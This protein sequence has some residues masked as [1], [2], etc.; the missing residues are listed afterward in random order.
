MVYDSVV[1]M[2]IITKDCTGLKQRGDWHNLLMKDQ[3][4]V[5]EKISDS[6][7]ITIK[8]ELGKL[9]IVLQNPQYVG[10]DESV[11]AAGEEPS[12]APATN[13]N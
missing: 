2:S 9:N 4:I 6:L 5:Q 3:H 12:L 8:K 7:N 13:K 10:D 1:P 11:Y